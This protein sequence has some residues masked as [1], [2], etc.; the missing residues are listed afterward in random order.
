[1]APRLMGDLPEAALIQAEQGPGPER[2]H[3]GSAGW[4][5]RTVHCGQQASGRRACIPPAQGAGRPPGPAWQSRSDPGHRSAASSSVQHFLR[6]VQPGAGGLLLAQTV[7]LLRKPP[8]S[9]ILPAP[10][11]PGLVAIP[12]FLQLHYLSSLPSFLSPFSSSLY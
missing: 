8:S 7:R 9:P 4:H 1:M 5:G 6:A 11:L 3:S 12:S 2:P 10:L